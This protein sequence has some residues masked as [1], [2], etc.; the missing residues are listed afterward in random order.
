[1]PMN[2]LQRLCRPRLRKERIRIPLVAYVVAALRLLMPMSA[3]RMR[4]GIN[5]EHR[6]GTGH[7]NEMPRRAMEA[8][9]SKSFFNCWC[10]ACHRPFEGSFIIQPI[11]V[12]I[13]TINITGMCPNC[14]E[15]IIS[16]E[17]QSPIV[18][19]FSMLFEQYVAS[20]GT[21]ARKDK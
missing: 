11:N 1:M 7:D 12:E 6:N 17:G 21:P 13:V 8:K 9:Q 4:S 14:G 16:W 10:S 3:S 2:I 19:D 18:P 20:L 15:F 5:W